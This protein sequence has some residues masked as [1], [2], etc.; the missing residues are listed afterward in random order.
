MRNA[1]E[2]SRCHFR[3]AKDGD[4]FIKG[5]VGCKYDGCCLVKLSDQVEEHGAAGFWEGDVSQF[6]YN[7]FVPT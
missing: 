7:G 2:Q 5:K 1:V 3:V 4:P 6:V